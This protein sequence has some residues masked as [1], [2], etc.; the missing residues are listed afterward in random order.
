MPQGCL[1]S[2]SEISIMSSRR[3]EARRT[4]PP[5]L[6]SQLPPSS[7]RSIRRFVLLRSG[8]YLLLSMKMASLVRPA[9]SCR[10]IGSIL[11]AKRALS[12]QA[13]TILRASSSPP[14]TQLLCLRQRPSSGKFEK[15]A[16][17]SVGQIASFHASDRHQI[18]PPLPRQYPSST[19]PL[20]STDSF[21]QS[22]SKE[23]VCFSYHIR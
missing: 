5:L 17:S 19:A 18:L 3:S 23:P 2:Q 20:A 16:S 9:I 22:E 10:P 11:P 4:S 14:I 21:L 7:C 12:H 15:A 13:S 8:T 6:A 1:T